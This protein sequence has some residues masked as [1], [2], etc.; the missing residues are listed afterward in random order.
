MSTPAAQSGTVGGSNQATGTFAVPASVVVVT[1][2][3]S[4]RLPD[5]N[6]RRTG[7][8]DKRPCKKTTFM[9]TTSDAPW[10]ARGPDVFGGSRGL[11]STEGVLHGLL[12]AAEGSQSIRHVGEVGVDFGDHA[13]EPA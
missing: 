8:L 1:S 4:K 9:M 3:D 2:R 7:S 13:E 11:D 10:P 6:S 5:A 12:S